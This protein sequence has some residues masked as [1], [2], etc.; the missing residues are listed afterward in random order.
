MNVLRMILGS[1]EREAR[2]RESEELAKQVERAKAAANAIAAAAFDDVAKMMR[3]R[4]DDDP[5]DDTPSRQ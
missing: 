3:R 5:D 4:K 2:Q 1:N